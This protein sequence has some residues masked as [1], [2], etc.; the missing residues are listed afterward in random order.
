MTRRAI[1]C[2]LFAL[3]GGLTASGSSLNPE[4]R[5]KATF[6]LEDAH[7]V[8]WFYVPL[9]RK[10]LPLKELDPKQRPLALALLHAAFS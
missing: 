1:N 7:R 2:V 4:Q 9:A 10:G 5:K 8:E 3:V 6:A